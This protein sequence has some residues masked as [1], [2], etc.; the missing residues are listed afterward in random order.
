MPRSRHRLDHIRIEPFLSTTNFSPPGL[1]LSKTGVKRDWTVHGSKL[2]REF[3]TALT[4]AHA[5]LTQRD[6]R[7]QAGAEGIYLEVES[8]QGINLP[9]LN[10]SSQSI[11]LGALKVNSAGAEIGALFI[12]TA[13]ESFLAT[14][15]KEYAHELT[16][17]NEPKN[18]GRFAPIETIRPGSLE[19]LWTD[20]RELPKNS[21]ERI[22][23]ECWCWADLVTHLAWAAERLQLRASERRLI[24]PEFEV[25]PVFANRREITRL[26]QNSDAVAELRQAMDSPTFFMT[27]ARREQ[28]IWVDDLIGRIE[29]ARSDDPAV[30]IL[31]GGVAREHP[32]LADSLPLDDCL[33]IDPD[34]GIDDHDPHGHGTNMAGTVLYADLTYP[35]ADQRI[36]HLTFQLESVKFLPPPS[37]L[38][39][40]PPAYGAITQGAVSLPEIKNPNRPRVFCMAVTNEDLS[41][42]RPTSWSAAIDQIC[43]GTMPGDGP[44]EHGEAPRRLFFVSSGNIP[45]ASDPDEVADPDEF[46]IEDPAQAWNAITVGGFTDKAEIEAR[47]GLEGWTGVAE[48]GDRSPYSRTSTDWDHARSPMKPEIVFEAGNRAINSSRSE[49]LSGVDSLSLLTTGKHFLDHPLE[50]FWATSPATAQATGMAG[51]IMA[52]HPDFWPET[53]RALMVHSAEWTPAMERQVRAC[54]GRKRNC[55]ALARSFGYGVPRLDRA[56]ASAQNDLALVA[57]SHIQPFKRARSSDSQGRSV[58]SAPTFSE[59]QYFQLPWP[60]QTLEELGATNVRLKITLSYFIEPSPGSTAPVAPE[61]YR[62]FGLRYQLKRAGETEGAF[63]HRINRLEQRVEKNPKPEPDSRWIFGK[64]SFAAGSL[65]CDIW[66]GP[67][68]ELAARG[69]LAI[70]PVSGWWRHR[71]ALHRYNSR[72][73]YALVVTITADEEDVELYTEIANLIGLGIETEISS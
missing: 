56:L 3:V 51:A 18:K 4:D 42:E 10:W 69:W 14:K 28:D 63:R 36:I 17:K 49:L 46:P 5:L 55:I 62:A 30:C 25:I 44:D 40:E 8:T 16:P 33:T 47:E 68:V 64:Q 71:P 43:S 6:S 15:I 45:D 58:V 52:R 70:Y 41:G 50:T 1:D 57:Q 31:D 61:R 19:S 7:A 34:W 35:L 24:F 72:S 39:T 29:A 37:F 38:A 66:I 21:D 22:W 26:L 9:D 23:W 27:T 32:L 73:R 48:V 12:P 65:H 2:E 54:R 59:V 67:A 20:P 11:R 53:I 60:R 13:A